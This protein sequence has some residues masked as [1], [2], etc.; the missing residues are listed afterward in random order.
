VLVPKVQGLRL[1]RRV[2]ARLDE[3]PTE[4][5]RKDVG[6]VL[7]EQ[8]AEGIA[9][10]GGRLKWPQRSRSVPRSSRTKL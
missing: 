1:V 9:R 3:L 2:I 10:A 5:S 4:F 6:A 7:E 8:E